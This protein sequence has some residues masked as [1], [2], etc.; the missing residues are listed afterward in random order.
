MSTFKT[1]E[2]YSTCA[3]Y[4]H[5][6]Y[7]YPSTKCSKCEKFEHYDYRCPSKSQHTD[8]VQIDDIDNSRIVKDAHIPS[9]VTSDVDDLIKSRTPIL[10]EIHVHE[11]IISDIQD[12]LVESRTPIPD[13]INV[14][15][16]DTSDSEHVL[17]EFSLPVQVAMYSLVIPIIEAKN[18]HETVDISVVTSSKPSKFI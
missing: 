7:E 2:P 14:S 5:Y 18:K 17:V 15:E 12:A 3:E 10:D 16:E 6:V 11:E 13:D 8:N 4:E 1:R 9:K